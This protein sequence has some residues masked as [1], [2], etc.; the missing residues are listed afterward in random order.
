MA[1]QQCAHHNDTIQKVGEFAAR[2]NNLEKQVDSLVS[3]LTSSTQS[4]TRNE[5]EIEHLKESFEE[6]KE[7]YEL[8]RDLIEQCQTVTGDL[9]S[10]FE[11]L[12][13]TVKDVTTL[14]DSK[15]NVTDFNNYKETIAKDLSIIKD[16][17]NS[18]ASRESVGYA[19]ALLVAIFMLL[20]GAAVKALFL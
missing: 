11:S 5:I 12:A 9:A 17:V 2:L 1:E 14:Y 6:L 8:N 4:D 15:V 20:L 3:R 10:K 19:I 7:F 13:K 18:R 16:D